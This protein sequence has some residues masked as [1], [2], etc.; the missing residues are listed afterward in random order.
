MIPDDYDAKMESGQRCLVFH[1][2]VI[3]D[4]NDAPAAAA[5]EKD[6]V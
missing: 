2:V 5:A 6:A 4:V 3:V 1:G